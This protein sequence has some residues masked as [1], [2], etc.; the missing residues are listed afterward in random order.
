MEILLL[1]GLDE[2]DD[3]RGTGPDGVRAEAGVT[4]KG[5]SLLDTVRTVISNWVVLSG[6]V[7][8]G[9]RGALD[10]KPKRKEFQR[11]RIRNNR[12]I[13]T[14]KPGHRAWQRAA[15]G[16]GSSEASKS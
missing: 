7:F 10:L 14:R 4:G 8:D 1:G 3:S 11:C 13:K 6:L 12:K 16:A 15:K 5:S 2:R 9:R